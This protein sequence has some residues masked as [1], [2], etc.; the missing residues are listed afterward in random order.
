M[1]VDHLFWCVDDERDAVAWVERLGLRETYRRRHVGQGTSNICCAFDDLFLELLWVVDVEEARGPLISPTALAARGAWRRSGACPVGVALRGGLGG[2][3]PTWAFTPP[4]L[5]PG[6][7]IRIL[8]ASSEPSA[9]LVFGALESLRPAEWPEARRGRLQRDAGRL[10]IASIRL[11]APAPIDAG[12]GAALAA[13][14]VTVEPA[15]RWALDL[16]V[17]RVDGGRERLSLHG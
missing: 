14:G 11:G 5:P 10:G 7:A 4:Y 2:L 15:P 8:S 3:G 17:A 9:P 16:T 6:G 1:P 12:V 13:A